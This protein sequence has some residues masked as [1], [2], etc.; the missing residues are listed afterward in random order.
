MRAIFITLA[1]GICLLLNA[2]SKAEG[3]EAETPTPSPKLSCKIK[4]SEVKWFW[5]EI[6][7]I[8]KNGWVSVGHSYT[9]SNRTTGCVTLENVCEQIP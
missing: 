9:Q 2:C 7:P 8:D 3:G 5:G 4:V 1:A 6:C